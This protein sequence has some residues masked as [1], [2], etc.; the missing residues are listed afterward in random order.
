MRIKVLFLILLISQLIYTQKSILK[1]GTEINEISLKDKNDSQVFELESSPNEDQAL[2]FQIFSNEKA[3]NNIQ[4][5]LGTLEE[6]KEGESSIMEFKNSDHSSCQMKKANQKCLYL[7]NVSQVKAVNFTCVETPCSA[8]LK[9]YKIKPTAL[10]TDKDQLEITYEQDIILVRYKIIPSEFLPTRT[11]IETRLQSGLSYKVNDTSVQYFLPQKVANTVTKIV[12]DIILTNIRYTVDYNNK[13]EIAYYAIYSGKKNNNIMIKYKHYTDFETIE[14]NKVYTDYFEKTQFP[15]NL[16]YQLNVSNFQEYDYIKF[17]FKWYDLKQGEVNI[18][19]SC[20]QNQSMAQSFWNT[21]FSPSIEYES[22]E[23]DSQVNKQYSLVVS[24]RTAQKVNIDKNSFYYFGLQSKVDSGF[25]KFEIQS[26]KK[27][28]PEIK[29]NELIGGK[30]KGDDIV[31]IILHSPRSA[32]EY[33]KVDL[34]NISGGSNLYLR[35]CKSTDCISEL[36]T[37]DNKNQMES[38]TSNLEIDYQT[39]TIQFIPNCSDQNKE[40]CQ[41]IIG[42]IPT[43][44]QQ[45]TEYLLEVFT[46]QFKDQ[47][48]KL[49]ENKIFENQINIDEYQFYALFI[50]KTSDIK[51]ISVKTSSPHVQLYASVENECMH[52]TP[53]CKGKVLYKGINTKPIVINNKNTQR[54]VVYVGIYGYTA[55][56]YTVIVEVDRVDQT[57]ITQVQSGSIYY[58]QLTKNQNKQY[59]IFDP[60]SSL[61]EE[62]QKNYPFEDIEINVRG[63]KDK[64]VIMANNDGSMPYEGDNG[65]MWSSN[66]G[67]LFISRN[68]LQFKKNAVYKI[69]LMA[70]EHAFDIL[71]TVRDGF[72]SSNEIQ[73]Q[74]HITSDAHTKVVELGNTINDMLEPEDQKLYQIHLSNSGMSYIIST[75][76]NDHANKSLK[77][78]MK[79]GSAP[80]EEGESYEFNYDFSISQYLLKA[81]DVD[82]L[83]KQKTS[84]DVFISIQ[85]K[86]NLFISFSLTVWNRSTAIELKEGIQFQDGIHF[87]DAHTNFY[88]FPT[89][90]D[91]S[92]NIFASSIYGHTGF[93]VYIFK[94]SDKLTPMN[95]P[96]PNS[97]DAENLAKYHFTSGIHNSHSITFQAQALDKCWPDCVVLISLSYYKGLPNDGGDHTVDIEENPA[98]KVSLDRINDKYTILVSTIYSDL[99][100]NQQLEFTIDNQQSKFF[101]LNLKNILAENDSIQISMTTLSGKAAIGAIIKDDTHNRYPSVAGET[102]DVVSYSNYL[103]ISNKKLLS[104]MKKQNI[105]AERNPVLIIEV[106]CVSES[107]GKFIMVAMQGN[108]NV[109]DVMHGIPQELYL[110][111]GQTKYFKYFHFTDTDFQIKLSREIGFPDMQLRVCKKAKT[112]SFQDFQKCL[113]EVTPQIDDQHTAGESSSVIHISRNDTKLYCLNCLYI[114]GLEVDNKAETHAFL[115][116]LLQ[117]DFTWLQEGRQI[118]D[119]V[120]SKGINLYRLSVD[121]DE[122]TQITLNSINGEVELYYSYRYSYIIK[123]YIGPLKVNPSDKFI[124]KT[125]R[126]RQ[127]LEDDKSVN[128]FNKPTKIPN[129]NKNPDKKFNYDQNSQFDDLSEFFYESEIYLCVKNVDKR[130]IAANYSLVFSAGDEYRYI[131]DGQIMGS[132][133][134]PQKKITYLYHHFEFEAPARLNVF[135]HS[136]FFSME[137]HLTVMGYHDL[138]KN[139]QDYKDITRDP[140]PLELISSHDNSLSY[141]LPERNGTYE[142]VFTNEHQTKTLNI[143]LSIN[144]RDMLLVP[145]T[146]QI[147]HAMTAKSINYYEV[148][149]PKNGYITLTITH[150][151]GDFILGTTQDYDDFLQQEYNAE[152]KSVPGSSN[153]FSF[154]VNKGPVFFSV[155]TS[156]EESF[157]K[158]RPDFFTQQKLIPH[159]TIVA[160]NEGVIYHKRKVGGQTEITFTPIMCSSCSDEIRNKAKVQYDVIYSTDVEILNVLGKCGAKNYYEHD[161]KNQ[162]HFKNNVDPKL[163]LQE[164]NVKQKTLYFDLQDSQD[165]KF[166]INLDDDD[167]VYYLSVVA[168]ISSIPNKDLKEM[169]VFYENSQVGK[170]QVFVQGEASV[171]AFL[172]ACILIMI[173]F[174]MTTCLFWRKYKSMQQGLEVSHKW[175]DIEM[176]RER[177]KQ[178]AQEK[179]NDS[180]I[181]VQD[182]TQVEVTSRGN[183]IDDSFDG[184]PFQNPDLLPS[185]NDLSSHF[186]NDAA[187]KQEAQAQQENP[188]DRIQIKINPPPSQSTKAG[189]DQLIDEN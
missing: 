15:K 58:G 40:T 16:A 54:G 142:I 36:Y 31:N 48:F 179:L 123:D 172:F 55:T 74:L 96:F 86:M 130:G 6:K 72:S 80:F 178:R 161:A 7:K 94:N 137:N 149:A 21:I 75:H 33:I 160:G 79:V 181:G 62:E 50:D 70:T 3:F 17:I 71:P 100:F 39:K 45:D 151:T 108:N 145:L 112:S 32:D 133:I 1:L 188:F 141:G 183:N 85:S 159:N 155:K 25:F 146:Y 118:I 53:D 126:P 125:I 148:I 38:K 186:K 18:F 73:Y 189:Y 57:L 175:R 78:L 113:Q 44:S 88:F 106:T 64:I 9:V 56:I 139:R 66:N 5:Q 59:F 150:C 23:S 77:V 140:I 87:I 131:Y 101:Y 97:S 103:E 180:S 47:Q 37:N 68:D 63:A 95:L 8:S 89:N 176:Q 115:S 128:L 19:A 119:S 136:K 91:H 92:L 12:G 124:H 114:I 157:F 90:K 41:Y 13:G 76:S 60:Y 174:C 129:A 102:F 120:D 27:S 52:P 116:V 51:S 164:D 29:L 143:S 107:A 153:V 144:S 134:P 138:M 81:E 163:V 182:T 35:E 24:Q 42:L 84:C 82:K 166:N 110:K 99:H 67:V 109:I 117:Q 165:I 184:K 177:R 26:S 169:K 156:L 187:P 20:L 122:E 173:F 168:T 127:D 11:V 171:Y 185:E 105:T 98:D 10:D 34:R 69:C 65:F 61:S 49:T 147:E 93:N 132:S 30:V 152:F 170:V 104:V 2:V 83:C 43:N 111:D 121:S 46:S 14:I 154:K 22:K 4:I 167:K 135:S 28:L 162:L 158:L